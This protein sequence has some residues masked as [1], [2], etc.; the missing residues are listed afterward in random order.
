MK[1]K[2]VVSS[3]IAA[4]WLA[5]AVVHLCWQP[6]NAAD[7]GLTRAMTESG[8]A[9]ITGI[10]RAEGTVTPTATPT[11]T[12]W[13]VTATSVPTDVFAA[14]TAKAER[15]LQAATTGTIRLSPGTC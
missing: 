9:M 6:V 15:T 3:I 5:A 11:L 8:A 14:A 7:V 12:P 1:S 13:I 2:H 4:L 10:I